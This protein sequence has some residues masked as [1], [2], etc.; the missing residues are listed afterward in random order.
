MQWARGVQG[1]HP[2]TPDRGRLTEPS[3]SKNP[4][5]YVGQ[6]LQTIACTSAFAKDA[7]QK[8][9][10]SHC[11]IMVSMVCLQFMDQIERA[12]A[13]IEGKRILPQ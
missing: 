11:N 1:H 10:K 13:V 9:I 12:R 7:P 4:V 6:L 5:G 2:C 3:E 8:K